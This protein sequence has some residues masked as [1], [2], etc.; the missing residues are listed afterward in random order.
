[1]KK[2][3]KRKLELAK[4]T[5]RQLTDPEVLRANG[6]IISAWPCCTGDQSGCGT[7]VLTGC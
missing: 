2:T 6:G 7:T 3:R 1:M 5:V 4:E